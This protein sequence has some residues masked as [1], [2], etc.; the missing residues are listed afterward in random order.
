MRG[1]GTQIRA[2]LEALD[3]DVHA[4]YRSAGLQFRPRFAPVVR[5]IATKGEQ[6]LRSLE[7]K[8]G[9]SQAAVSQTISEMKRLGLVETRPGRDARERQVGLSAAT[10]QIL[11]QLIVIWDA[12]A[13]AAEQ[14]DRELPYPLGTIVE[15]ALRA[16]QAE[17]FQA[18]MEKHLHSLAA[19]RSSAD[20][21]RGR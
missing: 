7:R 8:M 11:P 19:E 17:P 21:F 15:E 10:R 9:V 2:L 1:L 12:A 5:E 20:K 3:G 6:T 14:L 16:L 13:A 4:V 18:R